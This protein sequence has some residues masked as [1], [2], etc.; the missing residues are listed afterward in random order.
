MRMN[1]K[2]IKTAFFATTI[3]FITF[4]FILQSFAAWEFSHYSMATH[5]GRASLR[6]SFSG[7]AGLR[8]L[9]FVGKVGGVNFESEAFLSNKLIDD[10]VIL[11][12]LPENQDGKRLKIYI[13]NDY[14]SFLRYLGSFGE[15]IYEHTGNKIFNPTIYDWQLKPI[16]EYA[17]SEYSGVVS[18]FGEGDNRSKYFYIEYH[19]AFEDTLLG[20][21]LFQSDIMLI[22]IEHLSTL[23]KQDGQLVIEKGEREPVIKSSNIAVQTIKHMIENSDIQSWV[24]TDIEYDNKYRQGEIS[25]TNNGALNINVYP[26]YYF[27]KSEELTL[28]SEFRQ[29]ILSAISSRNYNKQQELKQKLE[30]M[31]NQ[32]NVIPLERQ[33]AQV[34][35]NSKLLFDI[36]PAVYDAV[37]KTSQYSAL[38]RLVK[39]NNNSNWVDYIKK[40]DAVTISQI[41]TPSIWEKK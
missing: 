24:L 35:N 15:Y 21:R 19:P 10:T 34:R 8:T 3:I 26:Y 5:A 16:S 31:R 14:L 23:P 22:D 29:E 12:Y 40:I 20:L 6:S 9:S 4:T 27:W 32:L 25:I 17:N 33:I 41:E 11:D 2:L 18:L 7:I 39:K 36:N 37:I 28:S 30:V 38:F 13:G 1:K